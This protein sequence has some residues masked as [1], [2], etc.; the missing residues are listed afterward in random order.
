MGLRSRVVTYIKALAILQPYPHI[1]V[2]LQYAVLGKKMHEVC[3]RY[4]VSDVH[5]DVL[6]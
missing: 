1:I 3:M 6:V 4:L 5:A 2:S